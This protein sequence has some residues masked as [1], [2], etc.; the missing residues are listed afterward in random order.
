MS[1]R[2]RG[3]NETVGRI[4][5]GINV[6]LVQMDI[7]WSVWTC[8]CAVILHNSPWNY[9]WSVGNTAHI[10]GDFCFSRWIRLPRELEWTLVFDEAGAS[11]QEIS[12]SEEYSGS[13]Y[14]LC[15]TSWVP[16]CQWYISPPTPPPDQKSKVSVAKP[17]LVQMVFVSLLPSFT[18][19]RIL[20]WPVYTLS[21]KRLLKMKQLT[22]PIG[23]RTVVFFP[24]PHS[25]T[26]FPALNYN[27]DLQL[28]TWKR[29]D[30]IK[31]SNYGLHTESTN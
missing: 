1:A 15:F 28:A 5:H 29:H 22:A 17:V 3:V 27:A 21:T 11:T 8:F 31:R 18:L 2:I 23:L 12:L 16:L 26:S 19:L 9:S 6:S 24:V 14:P 30:H 10:F 4:K 20:S 13:K 25:G 7:W